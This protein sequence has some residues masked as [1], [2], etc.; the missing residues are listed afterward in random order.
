[1]TFVQGTQF[2]EILERRGDL[3]PEV[4]WVGELLHP[5]L[6]RPTKHLESHTLLSHSMLK[7]ARRRQRILENRDP[8]SRAS[9]FYIAV[10]LLQPSFLQA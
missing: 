2:L 4:P 5:R 6:L 7:F 9:K 1:M 10:N 3:R 8:Y